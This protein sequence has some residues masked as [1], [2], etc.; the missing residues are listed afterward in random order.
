MNR[1][2]A[3]LLAP[4]A[5]PAEERAARRRMLGAFILAAALIGAAAGLLET[6]GIL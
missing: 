3:I 1:A 2:P 6:R 5:M 4:L